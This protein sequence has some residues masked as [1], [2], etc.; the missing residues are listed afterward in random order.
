MEYLTSFKGVSY[1]TSSYYV[2]LL[3]VIKKY[4][5]T[6]KKVVRLK[7]DQPDQWRRPCIHMTGTEPEHPS[8][9]A[10]TRVQHSIP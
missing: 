5:R 7:P 3:N 9:P 1:F 8:P 10:H 2:W 4:C 6:W